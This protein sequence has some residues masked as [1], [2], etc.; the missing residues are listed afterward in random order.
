MEAAPYLVMALLRQAHRNWWRMCYRYRHIAA[1]RYYD[2]LIFRREKYKR[3]TGTL[4]V[5]INTAALKG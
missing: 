1:V 2:E 3:I 5:R 4:D